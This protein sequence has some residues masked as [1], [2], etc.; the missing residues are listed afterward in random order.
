MMIQS[1]VIQFYLQQKWQSLAIEDLETML[2]RPVRKN[3]A[4]CICQ[5]VAPSLSFSGGH[6]A[7]STIEKSLPPLRTF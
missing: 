7:Q 5:K 2:S 4:W 3:H 6:V 1:A